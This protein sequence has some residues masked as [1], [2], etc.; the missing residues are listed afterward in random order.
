MPDPFELYP[1][2][3]KKMSQKNKKKLIDISEIQ[4]IIE[5]KITFIQKTQTPTWGYNV[6]HIDGFFREIIKE[7]EN[8]PGEKK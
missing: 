6:R 5:K 7:I 2:D 8:L 3:K 1:E 4:Q